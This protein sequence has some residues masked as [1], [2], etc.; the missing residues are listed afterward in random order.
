MARS[1][2]GHLARAPHPLEE[3][4]GESYSTLPHP[5]QSYGTWL[6]DS[7]ASDSRN[8]GK[9][10]PL[11]DELRAEK[12]AAVEKRAPNAIYEVLPCLPGRKRINGLSLHEAAIGKVSSL[13]VASRKTIGGHQP[14]LS[15][16]QE[17]PRSARALVLALYSVL[18]G[19]AAVSDTFLSSFRVS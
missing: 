19:S 18:L 5:S 16:S 14:F 11:V 10:S 2:Q 17:G 7:A 9:A 12:S 6:S 13:V 8:G 1:D 4:A 3:G 15:S